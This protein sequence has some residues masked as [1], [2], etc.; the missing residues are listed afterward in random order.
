MMIDVKRLDEEI[1]GLPEGWIVM[2][3]T[4]P[5]KSLDLSLASIKALTDKGFTGVVISANRPY[6]SLMSL[7]EK[8]GI[9]AGKVRVI[10][11]ISGKDPGNP[12]GDRVVFLEGVS[13][14]T[15]IS[16]AL[17]QIIDRTQGKRFVFIDSITTMLIYNAPEIFA[18]FTHNMLTR[19]R[20][21]EVNG[22]LITLDTETNKE[23]RA[24]IGQ[25][26]DKIIKF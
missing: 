2:L 14:L 13:A 6:K 25:L 5:E 16:Y 1:A 19:M 15:S 4:P 18:R 21:A 26:C 22:L 9:D 7:Y 12:D 17:N 10:D 11:C 20:I 8:N 23:I 24:E 3:E